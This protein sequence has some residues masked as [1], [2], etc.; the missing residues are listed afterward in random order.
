MKIKN[1]FI[2]VISLVF[3]LTLAGCGGGGGGSAPTAVSGF[4]KGVI[5]AKGSI[6]VN[7]VKFNSSSAKVRFD[8]L[9]GA[10]IDDSRLKVGMVVKIKGKI[11]DVT[12]SGSADK[13]E[14]SDNLEGP[15]GA[16]SVANNTL[17]VFGQTILVDNKTVFEGFT[18]LADPTLSVGNRVEVS[19]FSNGPNGILAT[20]IEKKTG[21]SDDF[22]IKGT[23]TAVSPG[24]NSFTLTPPNSTQPLTVTLGPGV[25][26]PALNSFVEVRTTGS[27]TTITATKVEL[28]DE[29][30]ADDKD[31]VE[32]EGFVTSINTA[33]KT[34][35]VNGVTVDAS[36]MT[37]PTVGQKVEVEGT[38]VNGVL[39]PA[40]AIKIEQESDIKIEADVTAVGTSSIT[41]L[42]SLTG[43]VDSATIF[44]DDSS[45][46]LVNFSLADI[47][48]G[49]HLEIAAFPNPDPNN[50]NTGIISKVVRKSPSSQIVL[51]G[52]IDAS[53]PSA[54][55]FILLGLTVDA[56]G[57]GVQ[58]RNNDVPISSV[59]FF[60]ALTPGKTIV[61]AK[62]T[63][64][65]TATKTLTATEVEIEKQLP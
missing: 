55:T 21:V 12:K 26:M 3:T 35:V 59:T 49:D 19:G 40:K 42:G 31:R 28:E 23:V 45:A 41:L 29:L 15:I 11:D 7:G 37:M 63:T 27:G 61:K 18:G 33:D 54:A 44:K 30:K 6:T 10:G 24:T 64:F 60:A 20:R 13:I 1:V 34:F 58:F 56:S 65:T 62:G 47:R 48:V 2:S 51:Q 14:F 25:A 4:S 9:S 52:P 43:F 38:M 53:I 57:A 8:N 36:A 5:T 17:T 50:P 46:K 39:V 22:E 32:V 16:I